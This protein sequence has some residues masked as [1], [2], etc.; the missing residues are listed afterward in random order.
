MK[1]DNIKKTFCAFCKIERKIYVKKH[2]SWTNVVGSV[3]ASV[4]ISYFLWQELDG[5]ALIFFVSLVLA[6]DILIRVRW[7]LG[8]RCPHC[9][10]DPILYKTNRVLLI[11]KVKHRLDELKQSDRLML[12]SKNPFK[13]LAV[14][15]IKS[16]TGK[17]MVQSPRYISRDL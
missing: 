13:N 9:Y 3:F 14:V 1:K 6:S 15:K 17:K 10:F 7:R 5:R 16:E 2:A 4:L 12:K 11:E 8:L